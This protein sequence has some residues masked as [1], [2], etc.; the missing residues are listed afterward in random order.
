[1]STDPN[2]DKYSN[3]YARY[4]L[5]PRPGIIPDHIT[6][7]I[8]RMVDDDLSKYHFALMSSLSNKEKAVQGKIY[9][10]PD[11][12]YVVRDPEGKVREGKID[13]IKPEKDKNLE[14][15]FKDENFKSQVLDATLKVGH[16]HPL[17]R[18]TGVE[19]TIMLNKFLKQEG[20]RSQLKTC[21]LSIDD[22]KNNPKKQKEFIKAIIKNKI[23]AVVLQG[24]E[25]TSKQD[26]Y[27]VR[28]ELIKAGIISISPFMVKGNNQ[29]NAARMVKE[30]YDGALATVNTQVFSFENSKSI[31]NSI[32]LV[33]KTPEIKA[34]SFSK[35]T[36]FLKITDE[37]KTTMTTNASHIAKALDAAF[38][39]LEK[40]ED[41]A[42][43]KTLLDKYGNLNKIDEQFIPFVQE[44]EKFYKQ[45]TH[46]K[47]MFEV[48]SSLSEDVQHVNKDASHHKDALVFGTLL[49]SAYQL[50][51]EL[52]LQSVYA[53]E[54]RK[55]ATPSSNFHKQIP[56][57]YQ[58][59]SDKKLEPLMF[60]S[61]PL[62][63]EVKQTQETVW[64]VP[65]MPYHKHD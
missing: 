35:P 46:T 23:N 12:S 40:P 17:K 44:L 36:Y 21:I 48:H 11:G 60:Y 6:A 39:M 8:A 53:P 3:Y 1:M 34:T 50:I 29:E 13:F 65:I 63:T 27:S 19:A 52:A 54:K 55:D 38:S 26:Y 14:R 18:P 47:S 4:K 28:H 49:K 57:I 62:Q 31:F 41:K 59:I 16:T 37:M 45:S 9:L 51:D 32:K 61:I 33:D 30:H 2:K 64:K 7:F 25:K 58:I 22:F 43:I 56:D 10:S 24:S 20:E 5:V 42:K 15:L